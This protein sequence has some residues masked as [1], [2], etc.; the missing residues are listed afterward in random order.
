MPTYVYQEVLEDGSPGEAFEITRAM[1]DPEPTEHPISGR[2]VKR[3]YTVPR[4]ATRY[5]PG[6]TANKLENKNVEKAGFTKYERDKLTGR[7][8][9][10]A[11]RDKNAPNMLAPK[12]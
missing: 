8:H 1:N 6:Q 2:L 9:K 10:V 12:G 3:V 5:T 7:Y 11:G 4:L